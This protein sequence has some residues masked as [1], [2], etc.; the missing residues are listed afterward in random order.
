MGIIYRI[1]RICSIRSKFFKYKLKSCGKH[2]LIS[3]NCKFEGLK[4]VEIGDNFSAQDGLWLATYNEYYGFS[5]NPKIKIGNEV[6]ISRYCHIGSV[7]EIVI[8]DNVLIG[9]NV[10]INDHSHGETNDF[11][12]PR[13]KLPLI[14]KGKIEIGENCWIC[15][16]AIILGNITIGKNCVIAANSVVNKS[17]PDSCLIAGNPAKIIKLLK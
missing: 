8:H 14:S 6:H 17:F 10:L 3:K 9:N 13:Y 1:K 4:N 5:Y 15:D 16:N 12:K 7:N 11:S 2:P